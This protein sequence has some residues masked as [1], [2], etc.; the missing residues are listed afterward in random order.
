[1][2]KYIESQNISAPAT[3]EQL[4]LRSNLTMRKIYA[5]VINAA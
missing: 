1:M 3:I 4:Y 2:K 5:I